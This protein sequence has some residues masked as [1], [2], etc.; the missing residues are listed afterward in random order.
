MEF[1]EFD[2]LVLRTREGLPT[3]DYPEDFFPFESWRSSEEEIERVEHEL[4]VRLPAQY[5]EFMMRHG[6]G[7]FLFVDLLPV[8]APGPRK[9]DLV[10]VNRGS[11]REAGFLAVAPVGTGD[12]WGFTLTG[13]ECGEAVDFRFHEDGLREREAPGF[14]DF[15][16]RHGL[17]WDS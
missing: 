9:E 17:R 12:W 5:K 1:D 8:V 2:A 13:N 3:Q 10:S 4:D 15:L 6:G 14:L 16:V 7:G 11:L